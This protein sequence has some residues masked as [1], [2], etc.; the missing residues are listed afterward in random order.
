M[1]KQEEYIYYSEGKLKKQILL[2]KVIIGSILIFI[3]VLLLF[4]IFRENKSLN[5]WVNL[6]FVITSII[7]LIMLY[8]VIRLLNNLKIESKKSRLKICNKSIIVEIPYYNRN[9]PIEYIDQITLKRLMNN[10]IE[11]LIVHFKGESINLSNYNRLGDI[12]EILLETNPNIKI[13]EKYILTIFKAEYMIM[14]FLFAVYLVIF[15]LIIT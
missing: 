15:Y 2:L 10:N 3:Y 7:I 4:Y 13:T 1:V 12:F 14:L 5:A 6:D 9:I 11:I 8:F